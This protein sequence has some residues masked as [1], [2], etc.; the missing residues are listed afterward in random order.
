M[1]ADKM[2][3]GLFVTL[4][5]VVVAFFALAGLA[6]G[7]CVTA[8]CHLGD[9]DRPMWAAVIVTCTVLANGAMWFL[10]IRSAMK[11]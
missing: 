6:L 7:D 10:L 1:S 5:S 11:D 8:E 9:R 4:V 2:Y 3:L